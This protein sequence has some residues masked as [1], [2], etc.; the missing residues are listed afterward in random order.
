MEGRLLLGKVVT[1]TKSGYVIVKIHD[2]NM[3]IKIGSRV[4]DSSGSEVG[5][6]ADIIGNVE[7]PYAVVKWRSNTSP[8]D[9]EQLFVVIVRRR[10]GAR[11]RGG[12]KRVSGGRRPRRGRVSTRRNRGHTG[13][14]KGMPSRR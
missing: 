11:R 9:D 5:I 14:S 7:R 3:R 10:R 6:V 13:R 12:K 2:P 1:R 8:R 4:A